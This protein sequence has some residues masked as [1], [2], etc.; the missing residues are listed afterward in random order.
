MVAWSLPV[1]AAPVDDLLDALGVPQI[2]EIMREEGMAYG[3]EI[4]TDLLSTSAN[5][6]WTQTVSDIF[7]VDQM[8]GGAAAA[9]APPAPPPMPEGPPPDAKLKAAVIKAILKF[10]ELDSAPSADGSASASGGGL[11]DKVSSELE[12]PPT[13]DALELRRIANLVKAEWEVGARSR[14]RRCGGGVVAVWRCA[15]R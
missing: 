13:A 9:P 6:K 14:R 10:G 1:W 15:V 8:R 12:A 5:A 2:V 7:D 11:W 4:A 3:E